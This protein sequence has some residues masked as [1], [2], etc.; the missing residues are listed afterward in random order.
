MVDV[1][2]V[3]GVH[4][5]C[6]RLISSLESVRQQG[7]EVSWECLIVA[8]G[9]FQVNQRLAELLQRDSRLR[10]LQSPQSGLTSALALGCQQ[11][12]G[13]LI[14]RLDVG[15]VMAPMRLYSQAKAFTQHPDLVLATSD[16]EICGPVWEHLRTDTQDAA[17][18][19]P[20]RVDTAPHSLGIAI[21]IPHHASVMFSR[22]AYEAVGG[23]RSE[24]Y[25][26]QDWDL[27]YRLASKGTFVHLP[28]VLTRVRLFS[29][30]LSSRHWREQREIAKLSLACHA[31]RNRGEAETELLSMAAAVRPKPK[32]KSRLP[33]DGRRAEG[34]YFIAEA[35]RRN[36]DRRCEIYFKEALRF[37][38]WKPRIWLRALQS[39]IS[40][41]RLDFIAMV[42]IK[43]SLVSGFRAFVR[44]SFTAL[45]LRAS[46]RNIAWQQELFKK[47]SLQNLP[48]SF[49]IDLGSGLVPRNDFQCAQSVGLDIRSSANV[50]ACDLSIDAI[51][52]GSNAASVIT[53]F[54]FLEHVPR[55]LANSHGGSRFPFLDLMNEIYR[56]LKPGGLFFSSTPCY[57]WPMAYSDPTHVNIMTE[58]T[59]PNYFCEPRLWAQIYGFKGSFDL[60]DHGWIGGHYISLLR[61]T[62]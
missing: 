13:A 30:G 60:V 32:G 24:F 43:T 26:G 2:V 8:N 61:K 7:G 58:E 29:D 50:I 22:E 35:L 12:Q 46:P 55:V 17:T 34:A 41:L 54:D 25:F 38:F 51:P 11:A 20:M 16:V 31:A 42:S 56:V 27:W 28:E 36:G 10:V 33:W 57:P 47:N 48:G 14:A 52:Y 9:G 5:H 49:S 39:L 62:Q 3:L 15:D 44:S 23:Y 40:N 19:K 45:T 6:D 21:D 4:A 1:T 53:A 18:G 37:G 59:L